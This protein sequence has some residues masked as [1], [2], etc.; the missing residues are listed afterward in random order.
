M[1]TGF[2]TTAIKRL[3]NIGGKKIRKLPMEAFEDISG[4]ANRIALHSRKSTRCSLRMRT[5][6]KPGVQMLNDTIVSATMARGK[7]Q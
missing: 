5:V 2:E 1:V 7:N 3:V 4:A 6:E